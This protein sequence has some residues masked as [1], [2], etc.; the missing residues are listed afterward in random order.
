MGVVSDGVIGDDF[1]GLA[2]SSNQSVGD[3]H[4]VFLVERDSLLCRRLQIRMDGFRRFG[5]VDENVSEPFVVGVD[6]EIVFVGIVG[7]ADFF[8]FDLCT[9]AMEQIS[10]WDVAGNDDLSGHCAPFLSGER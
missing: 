1:D 8:V 9:F 3:E 5:E 7:R 4:A 2:G 10:G 6:H